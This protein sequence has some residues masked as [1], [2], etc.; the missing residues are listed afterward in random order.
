MLRLFLLIIAVIVASSFEPVCAQ[1]YNG[2][3]SYNGYSI[4]YVFTT[5]T[6]LSTYIN[7]SL[8]PNNLAGAPIGSMLQ[9]PWASNVTAATQN[10]VAWNNAGSWG[11]GV[12]HPN[13]SNQFGPYFFTHLSGGNSIANAQSIQAATEDPSHKLTN[14]NTEAFYAVEA[15][16]LSN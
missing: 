12:Q 9:I 11:A 13:I 3:V 16:P 7:N 6:N 2:P 15:L 1:T 4:Y 8:K 10:A 14:V 5:W